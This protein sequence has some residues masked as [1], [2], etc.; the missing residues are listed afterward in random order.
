M[1]ITADYVSKH[2]SLLIFVPN[3]SLTLLTIPSKWSSWFRVIDQEHWHVYMMLYLLQSSSSV[4]YS[5]LHLSYTNGWLCS[6]TTVWTC[7]V[8]QAMP[9]KGLHS[10]CSCSAVS[11]RYV[12]SAD[13][14]PLLPCS[15]GEDAMQDNS[16]RTTPGHGAMTKFKATPKS[17]FCKMPHC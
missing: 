8:V 4:D 10:S 7:E 2:E 3:P 16:K 17:V 15:R 14:H 11:N 1:W 12:E 5:N 6:A 13:T 9:H